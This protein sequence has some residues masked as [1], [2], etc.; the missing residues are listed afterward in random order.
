MS[1][2]F[3]CDDAPRTTIPCRNCKLE[4]DYYGDP[5]RKCVGYCDGTEEVSEAPELKLANTNARNVLALL[6][7]STDDYGDIPVADIPAV[8]Q[9]LLTAINRE[10]SRAHLVT[11]TMETR[12]TRMTEV[13]GMST[14]STGPR[15]IGVGNTDEQTLRRLR[16]AQKLL[17]WAV[18]NGHPVSWG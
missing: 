1:M 4:Q 10:S 9:R 7:L 18:E 3:W 14:I 8:M 2:T 15:M 16:A 13:N 17:S 6:G 11:E 5:T 12:T